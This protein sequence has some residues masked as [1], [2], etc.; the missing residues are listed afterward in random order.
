MSSTEIG[1]LAGDVYF[2]D[3]R[4]EEP[5]RGVKLIVLNSGGCATVSDWKDEYAFIGWC[6]LPLIPESV[7]SQMK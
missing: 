4:V 6:K 1:Y 2:K 5:P 7:K 3:P